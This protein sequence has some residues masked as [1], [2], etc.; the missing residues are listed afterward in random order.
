MSDDELTILAAL[1]IVESAPPLSDLQR[2]RLRLLMQT[3]I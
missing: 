2:D 3:T 1:A